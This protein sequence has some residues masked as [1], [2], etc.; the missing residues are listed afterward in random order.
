[1]ILGGDFNA[2]TKISDRIGS[3]VKVLKNFE[4]EWKIFYGLI[5]LNECEYENKISANEKMTWNNNGI[6]SRIDRFYYSKNLNIDLTYTDIK[7]TLKSDHKAVISSLIIGCDCIQ[8][9]KK[10]RPWRLNDSIL[11]EKE[12]IHG[13]EMICNK[14]E[15]LKMVHSNKW[16]DFFIES[17]VNFLKKK[18]REFNEIKEAKKIILLK[19]IDQINFSESIRDN[20]YELERNNLK[21]EIDNFY[22]EKRKSIEK[23]VHENRVKF[24][25]QPTKALIANIVKNNSRCE[26]NFFKK[27]NGEVTSDKKEIIDDLSLFY[28]GLLGVERVN[29]DEIK[30]YKFKINPIGAYVK[31]NFSEIG[32]KITFNEVFEVIKSIKDSSPGSNGLTIAFYKKFFHLFGTHFVEIL[33]DTPAPLPKSFNETIIKLINKNLNK[34]KSNNDLRPISLTNFEYRIYTKVLARRFKTVSPCLFLDYQTCSVGGRRINDSINA[35]IGCIEDANINEEEMYLCSFDQKKA[36][37]SMSHTYLFALLE[38]LDINPFL[39]NSVKRIYTQSFAYIVANGSISKDKILVKSSIKQGCSMSMFLYSGGIEELAVNIHNNIEIIGYRI[40]RMSTNDIYP[41]I[42]M[43]MYADD[44]AS[45]A[46]TLRTID[47]V[48]KEFKKWGKVSGASLNEDKTKILAINS[49]H[50]EYNGNK[51]VDKVKI[52]GITFNKYG[53]DKENLEMCLKKINISLNLWKS[54]RLD[55]LERIT[56]LRTFALSKLWYLCNFISLNEE[57]IKKL[58]T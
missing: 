13:M 6:S 1:M 42:K 40:P 18:S 41:V 3:R 21:N 54:V 25:K 31:E 53:I 52:L 45:A 44:V 11:N 9:V 43:T 15:G 51:F 34:I 47:L 22:E 35:I 8:N 19:R 24:C 17:V 39:N 37:D 10:Y 29:N 20:N 30:N 28:Q 16:Y 23:K 56:V 33:N 48:V 32:R 7:E 49:P 26:I 57:E 4:N 36:F 12:V 5:G 46:K 58:E 55:M 38:H 2:V 14:I 27:M 50:K